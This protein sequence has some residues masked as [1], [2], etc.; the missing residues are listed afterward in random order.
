MKVGDYVRNKYG[1][2]KIR[3]IKKISVY[4]PFEKKHSTTARLIKVDNKIC[5][6]SDTSGNRVKDTP[7][8]DTAI[9]QT[10]TEPK[11]NS[12]II[13]LLENGDLLEIEYTS[14]RSKERTTRLFEVE[15]YINEYFELCNHHMM[16]SIFNGKFGKID[17]ELNPVIKKIITK[18]ELLKTGYEVSK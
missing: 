8:L 10:T 13:K 18:E 17:K 16:F 15:K 14:P 6:Q 11:N 7:L 3:E 5:F 4:N 2:T 9:L 12:N 1:K